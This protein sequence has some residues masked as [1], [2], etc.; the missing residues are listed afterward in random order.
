MEIKYLD[1]PFEVKAVE[2]TGTF[3]GYLSVFGNVDGGGDIV[4]PGAFT[5]SL[6]AWKAKGAL[7]PVLWQHRTG[8]PIGAFLDMKQDSH[9]LFVKGQLL[10]ADIARA[11]EAR[12]LMKANAITG[13]S[14]GYTSVADSVDSQS[15]M[16]SIMKADLWEG[17]VVT[18]PMNGL[19]KV[20]A[21]K[22]AITELETLA[23]AEK[24]LRDA[25][26]LSRSQATA[27]IGR[28]KSLS[29]SDSGL[30]LDDELR[31]ALQ[32]LGTTLQG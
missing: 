31:Q 17:S 15:G 9:G 8:E 30:E 1:R 6:A 28:V 24:F 29:Q 26:N 32:R 3:E 7:P 16:R 23:D 10:V 20:T 14:I 27:F 12:A 25:G 5:D 21:V 11:R 22:E 19:A 2:E 18:F 13:M 4:M